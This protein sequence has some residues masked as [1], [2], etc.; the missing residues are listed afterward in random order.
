[1]KIRLKDPTSG[2]QETL[3]ITDPAG[4]SW[5]EFLQQICL[6]F[7]F[8]ASVMSGLT[9]KSAA[10]PFQ[11]LLLP[12]TPLSSDNSVAT[13]TTMLSSLPIRHGDSLLLIM[14]PASGAPVGDQSIAG[15]DAGNTNPSRVMR[16]HEIPDDNSCLFHAVAHVFR[17]HLSQSTDGSIVRYLRQKV[18]DYVISHPDEYSE[19][20]LGMPPARYCDRMMKSTTWGGAVELAIFAR[21]FSTQI[22]AIDVETCKPYVFGEDQSTEFRQR[23]YL[24]YSGVHYDCCVRSSHGA[25]V[26]EQT[27]F[28]ADDAEA[29]QQAL[30]VAEQERR[31]RRFTNTATFTLQCSICRQAIVGQ[32]EA[33]Q[34]AAATGH[35][36]FEEYHQSKG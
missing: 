28:N 10:P 7:D 14:L 30:A 34:H 4:T 22:C 32:M 2:R 12:P 6:T 11:Q 23:A 5:I 8:P 35:A 17:P 16:R 19:P 3:C 13:N 36:R 33:Q 24:L 15:G 31:A 9:L 21:H 25:A 27:I 20:I 1:M 26:S 29:F 18:C